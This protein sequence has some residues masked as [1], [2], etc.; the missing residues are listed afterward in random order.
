VTAPA[1]RG[2]KKEGLE[3]RLAAGSGAAQVEDQD[4]DYM[5]NHHEIGI[6]EIL[7]V[8][9]LGEGS[10]CNVWKGKCRGKEVLIRI[11]KLQSGSVSHKDISE[12]REEV[13]RLRYPLPTTKRF[14]SGTRVQRWGSSTLWWWVVDTAITFSRFLPHQ[15]P[16]TQLGALQ[17]NPQS[18]HR[19][20]HGRVSRC[21]IPVSSPIC[22]C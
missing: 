9:M 12:L 17:Q 21:S 16:P 22:A 7:V 19:A 2:G 6:K 5:D 3:P 8:E 13:K 11:L 10:F 1:P 4:V 20:L 18:T 14:F 15:H